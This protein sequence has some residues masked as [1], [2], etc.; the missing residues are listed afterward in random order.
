LGN[1]S[2]FK[3]IRKK[4]FVIR[5]MIKEDLLEEIKD[6]VLSKLTENNQILLCRKE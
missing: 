1:F 5:N 3:E 4:P 6:K 2:N